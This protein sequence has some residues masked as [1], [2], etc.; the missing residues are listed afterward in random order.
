MSAWNGACLCCR[1]VVEVVLMLDVQAD[2]AS[3][4]TLAAVTGAPFR[5]DV[6]TEELAGLWRDGEAKD[7][8]LQPGAK[9]SVVHR[10]I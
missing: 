3:C 9:V 2:G 6:W 5:G 4:F 7:V 1:P 10:G 8:R